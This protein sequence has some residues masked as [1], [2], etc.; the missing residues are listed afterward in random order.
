MPAEAHADV[1]RE[2]GFAKCCLFVVRQRASQSFCGFDKNCI[3]KIQI[4]LT[5][6]CLHVF[7]MIGYT[8]CCMAHQYIILNVLIPLFDQ[9]VSYMH[10]H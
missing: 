6:G 4:I 5:T 1:V 10:E 3:L 8:G 7:V 2:A 9:T